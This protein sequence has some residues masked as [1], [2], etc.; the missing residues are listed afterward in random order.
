MSAYAWSLLTDRYLLINHKKPCELTNFFEP[1]E[2]DWN[3][4][5]NQY[6]RSKAENLWKIDNEKFRT[7][8]EFYTNFNSTAPFI[9]IKNNLDW[10][11]PLSKNKFLERK[12]NS[13]GF[14]PNK[15]KIQFLFREWY[16]KLFKLN[17]RLQT[18]YHSFLNS[19]KL[20][21][22]NKQT[23]LVCAQVRIGGAREFVSHDA[24][25][26]DIKNSQIYWNYIK[27]NFTHNNNYNVFLTTDTRKLESEGT[28]ELGK[29]RVI[30][31]DG[32]NAHLDRETNCVN[33]D[34]TFLDFHSL[35]NCDM[36]IISESGFGKLGCWNRLK[37]N[38]NLVM[39]SKKQEIVIKK[40]ADDLFI[41]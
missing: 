32:I 24:P 26:T 25:F 22:K 8:L 3:F 12:I 40:S 23:K 7:D 38:D 16:Q 19:I 18:Q 33:V 27:N 28:N 2:H 21:K 34:K 17:S 15:F 9:S 11:E 4:N 1:N 14:K 29:D 6:D 35:Q 10:L 13:L 31:N 39:F 20:K 37:P 41:L 30:I 5:L 36:A